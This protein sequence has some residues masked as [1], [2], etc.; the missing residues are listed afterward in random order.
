LYRE[1]VSRSLEL[2]HASVLPGDYPAAQTRMGD[3]LFED[4][5]K[6]RTAEESLALAKA[7]G[8]Q[9]RHSQPADPFDR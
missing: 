4:R 8:F 5:G 1:V 9:A 7:L 3:Q 6:P 2:N